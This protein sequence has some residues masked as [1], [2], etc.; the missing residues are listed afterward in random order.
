MLRPKAGASQPESGEPGDFSD[1]PFEWSDEPCRLI[2][3]SR[4]R[5]WI[6]AFTMMLVSL[7]SYIDRNTLALFAPTML[8]D[9]HLTGE[10]Y[11]WVVSG[12]SIAY[13]CGNLLWGR[14]IDN[15]GLRLVMTAA[16]AF[17]SLSSASH[18]VATGFLSLFVART[19]LGFG[20]GATFPGGLRTVVQTLPAEKR[21]RGVAVAYS[22]GALG[23]VVTPIIMTPVFEAFGW[24]G[25]FWFTG[26]IGLLWLAAWQF[27]SRRSDLQKPPEPAVTA[28]SPERLNWRQKRFWSFAVIYAFGALPLGFVLY[29]APLYLKVLGK[30]QVELGHLLWIPPLGW[31]LGYFVWGWWTDRTVAGKGFSTAAYRSLFTILMLLSLPLAAVPFLPSFPAAMFA[32]FF[33]MF[34]ASGFIVSSVSYATTAF[35]PRDS[36]L[37]AGLGA[38]SWSALV[39]VIMPVAG[40]LFDLQLYPAAFL[41]AALFPFA[42]WA[43]WLALNQGRRRN[44]LVR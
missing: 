17:W 4:F 30:T 1:E 35:G 19:A 31:E 43:I 27:L 5:Q 13:L 24:R 29:Y 15:F 44:G 23:A 16:V 40:R 6:P 39:A 3:L 14:W 36:G 34:I 21:A 2:L 20:E 22:G 41:I 26:M 25:A 11:G 12:F 33:A 8:G 18:A 32:L 42:G 9:L 38:G 10:Q 7:I 28:A 37:V